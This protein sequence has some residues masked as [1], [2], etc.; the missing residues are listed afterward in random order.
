M[1][2]GENSTRRE[3]PKCTPRR[4]LEIF[5]PGTRRP[6]ACGDARFEERGWLVRL[7]GMILAYGELRQRGEEAHYGPG[8]GGARGE[9]RTARRRRPVLHGARSTSSTSR[10]ATGSASGTTATSLA[11]HNGDEVRAA[12]QSTLQ[13]TLHLN[14]AV[15]RWRHSATRA[16]R[17]GGASKRHRCIIFIGS[18]SE[19]ARRST[20]GGGGSQGRTRRS[21]AAV[22]RLLDERFSIN[23]E[24]GCS[25]HPL[26]FCTH[27]P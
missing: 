21:Y 25:K 12:I 4:F 9:E 16:E 15:T 17:I 13:S 14:Q 3:G 11:H 19:A 23:G 5:F 8:G 7:V 24:G 26:Y 18:P 6:L 1:A 27:I 2:A 10:T 22:S 20:T